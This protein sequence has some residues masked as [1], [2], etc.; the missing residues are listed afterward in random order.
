M[1]RR[2]SNETLGKSM[3]TSKRVKLPKAPVPNV[4][5][6]VLLLCRQAGIMPT[7][8][9]GCASPELRFHDT[10]QWRF[11][12]AWEDQ[13]LA[14]EI[15]GGLYGNG[16]RCPTCKRPTAGGHSS[17]TGIK[18]DMEKYN[19]ATLEG[20]AILRYTPEDCE[21]APGVVL[22][23]IRTFLGVSGQI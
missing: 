6:G 4:F 14:V 8:G 2:K 21:K 23:A 7:H 1:V 18:R 9:E 20:W 17:V 16:K 22:D 15:E 3:D 10:R 11:D 13:R 5:A 19:A 12:Y